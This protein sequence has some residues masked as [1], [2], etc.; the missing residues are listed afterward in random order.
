MSNFDVQ[1]ARNAGFNDDE[2]LN[3]LANKSG[4]D[5]VGARN[6][7]FNN[8]EIIGHLSA[9]KPVQEA[10]SNDIQYTGTVDPSLTGSTAACGVICPPTRP[11]P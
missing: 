3:H 7:G 11:E 10:A 4:Y 5:L 9:T 8:D 1:G 2:I 6:A